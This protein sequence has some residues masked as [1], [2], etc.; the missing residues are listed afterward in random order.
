MLF[1]SQANNLFE[2]CVDFIV[3]NNQFPPFFPFTFRP[4]LI[5]KLNGIGIEDAIAFR[6]GIGNLK[7]LFA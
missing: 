7:G 1:R 2:V 5:Q 6:S 3:A 4:N